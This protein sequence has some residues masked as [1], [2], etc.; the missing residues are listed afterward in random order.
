M[1]KETET[2]KGKHSI[3][4]PAPKMSFLDSAQNRVARTIAQIRAGHWL[5]AP[6]LKRIGMSTYLIGAGCVG[7][8]GCLALMCSYDACIWNWRA[9][10][11]W[12]RPDENGRKG[13]R[14]RSVGQLLGKA[15]WEKPLA[16]WIVATGVGLLGP[17][18]EDFE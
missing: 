5:C 14:P 4:P 6:C 1:A 18:K 17:G 2:E 8:G 12:D 3:L 13:K 16:D 11:I 15:K 7:N 9:Q 10:E